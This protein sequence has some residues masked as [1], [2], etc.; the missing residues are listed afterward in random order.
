MNKNIKSYIESPHPVEELLYQMFSKDDK[1]V[2]FDIGACEGEDSIR[3]RRIFPNS[4]V[5][6]FEPLPENYELL[7]K[8]ISTFSAEQ[9]RTFN[10]ALSDSSGNATLNVSSG[11]PENNEHGAEWNYGNKSSSLLEPGQVVRAHQ[12]LK[13]EKK[14][15]VETKTLHSVFEES[16][17]EMID[18]VHMD[19]QGAEMKVLKGAGASLKKINAIWLEVGE[20][21][22][23]QDQPLKK[24][25]EAFLAQN[26]FYLV[27]TL[28]QGKAGDQ[29]YIRLTESDQ[30]ALF[31]KSKSG[32][33]HLMKRVQEGWKKRGRVSY[34]QSGEDMIIQHLCGMLKLENPSYIDVGA[35][36]PFHLNNTSW[37]YENGSRGINIEPDPLQFELFRKHRPDDINLNIAIGKENKKC[38]L[39]IFSSRTLNT[40]EASEAERMVREENEKQI[41]TH[42]VQMLDLY[43]CILLFNGGKFPDMLMIDTEGLDWIILDQLDERK[44]LPKI[45]CSETINYSKNKKVNK[46]DELIRMIKNKGYEIYADT[47]INTIFYRKDAL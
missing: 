5:F 16:K 37:F 20:I 31:A 42:E 23:Y 45:I 25:I 6:S 28:S 27:K 39:H 1:L 11:S 12:W 4:L 9:I 41:A 35:H 26:N 29:L 21:E 33:M 2:I 15:N 10:L 34:S 32:L 46:N 22:Y 18:L 19:V 8:N 14:I 47:F 38:T 17:L 13:F 43:R 44:G 7:K 3:Y 24:D 40:M 36:D 30:N